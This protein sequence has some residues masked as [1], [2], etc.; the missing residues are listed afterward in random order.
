M[1]ATDITEN[2]YDVNGIRMHVIEAGPSDGKPIIFLHGFPDFWYDWKDQIGYFAAHGYHV[3]VPDQRGYNLTES[4]QGIK[5][6]R[7]KHLMEDICSL[8]QTMDLK[9]VHLVGHD[10]G[11]IVSWML[12]IYHPKLF[13]SIVILNAP[14]PGALRV[15]RPM[16]QVFKSWYIYFFQIP[17]L[18]EWLCSRNDFKFLRNSMAG[19]AV[20]GT[21]SVQGLERYKQAWKGRIRYMINWY[22]AMRQSKEFR[23]NMKT[24]KLINNPLLLIWGEKDRF[25]DFQLAKASMAFCIDGRLIS[26]PDATHWLQHEKSAEVNRAIMDFIEELPPKKA[27]H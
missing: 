12:G 24:P 3:I 7:C 17:R 26:F 5:A 27:V 8:V 25:L 2:F 21:F 15:K 11:G 4:P 1:K 19:T 16:L 18:P 23:E 14:H 22:R 13:K 20:P 6:Y 10:W 9:D